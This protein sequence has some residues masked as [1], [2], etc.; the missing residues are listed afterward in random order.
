MFGVWV[1][2]SFMHRLHYSKTQYSHSQRQTQ[3]QHINRQWL[4]GIELLK[5]I[6]YSPGAVVEMTRGGA[7]FSLARV[8]LRN[9]L[10]LFLELFPADTHFRGAG[11]KVTLEDRYEDI[12]NPQRI[13][14][15]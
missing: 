6:L 10:M 4:L 11:I 13:F 5:V 15:C 2:S 12:L 7:Y 8:R 14:L 1:S 9:V 3:T